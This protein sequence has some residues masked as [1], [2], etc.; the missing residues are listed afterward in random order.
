MKE[1]PDCEYC[2]W[3]KH[4]LW[5]WKMIKKLFGYCPICHRWFK[6]PA[7]RRVSTSYE[8]EIDNWWYSCKDCFDE[9]QGCVKEAWSEYNKVRI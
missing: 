2:G 5:I 8:N 7:V 6:Y 9:M 3:R 4:T 1:R